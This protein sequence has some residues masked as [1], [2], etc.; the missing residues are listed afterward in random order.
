M[1]STAQLSINLGLPATP[2]TKNQDLFYQLQILY[3]SINSLARAVDVYTGSIQPD[4]ATW[5]S[6]GFGGVRVQNITR[7]YVISDVALTA[8]QLVHLYDPGTGSVHARLANATTI[9]T[10][11]RGYSTGIIA[12][13]QE[14]EIVLQGLHPFFSGLT[15]GA[16]YYTSTTP[17]TVQVGQPST[18]GNIIQPVGFALNANTMWFAPSLI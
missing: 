18:P 9:A 4:P 15:A 2:D 16:I 3:N 11:A 17:G 5:G 12:A 8:G 14:A 7:I 10:P 6:I 13:G 1:A